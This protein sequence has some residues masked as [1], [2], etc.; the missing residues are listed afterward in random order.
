MRL[1]HFRL[2]HLIVLLVAL[3]P[4]T[5][6]GQ[7]DPR[8]YLRPLP[9][10]P[11]LKPYESCAFPDGLVVTDVTPM[12]SGV[13]ERPVQSHGKTG[14]VPLL[15]GRR[16]LFAYPDSDV[17][18]NAKVELLPEA[19]YAANRKL[20]VDDFNDILASDK[21]VTRNL[22]RKPTLNSFAIAGMDRSALKEK[23][24]GIYLLLDDKNRVATTIYFLNGPPAQ[25]RF[26]TLAD[27]ASLRDT[28]LYN[29]TRCIRNNQAS[30]AFGGKP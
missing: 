23:T 13:V 6:R 8:S 25:R 19:N 28:F 1:R 29:Y 10:N 20:L 2:L 21:G 7:V 14:T 16:V 30:A 26:K 24:L 17:Y 22:A 3:C 11:E 5:C 12:P 18:A 15:G 9:A 27:Y 4:T